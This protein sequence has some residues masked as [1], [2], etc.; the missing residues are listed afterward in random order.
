MKMLKLIIIFFSFVSLVFSQSWIEQQVS[1]S[2]VTASDNLGYAVSVFG[3]FAFVGAPFKSI[4][5]TP[6]AGVTYV[7]S[8]IGGQW[9]QFH[10]LYP[11]SPF[12]D[13]QYGFSVSVHTTYAIVGSPYD[14]SGNTPGYAYIYHYNGNKWILQQTISGSLSNQYFGYSVSIYGNYAVVGTIGLSS[15]S[16]GAA[17]IFSL[18][19][20]QWS[21]Q[22]SV[23]SSNVYSGDYF[24][25]SVSIFGYSLLVGAPHDNNSQGKAY[26]FTYNGNKWIQEAELT[27][28]GGSANDFFG[29]SVMIYYNNAI[30]GA[31]NQTISNNVGQGST[32]VFTVSGT[33]WTQSQKLTATQGQANSFFGTSVSIS[34]NFLVIGAPATPSNTTSGN[35]YVFQNIGNQ[36]TEQ[37]SLSNSSLGG[38]LFGTSVAISEN[39]IVVGASDFTVGNNANQGSVYF[40]QTT[41]QT[42]GN[43]AT[44]QLFTTVA[45]V[46]EANVGI[47]YSLSLTLLFLFISVLF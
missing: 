36:W 1:P 21:L 38:A 9:T 25:S 16:L 39:V 43:V 35:A 41:F 6:F 20:S 4:P 5:S 13:A 17:Y 18:S 15:G 42:T 45:A 19:G 37:Q 22:Q 34:G 12:S 40:Y 3:N 30:I 29:C 14:T 47:L 23:Y 10:E 33:Q 24:G 44:T 2:N 31:Y 11:P 28:N 46:S 32:Y 26:V 7:F 27:A 8:N